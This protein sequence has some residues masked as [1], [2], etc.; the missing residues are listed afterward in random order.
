MIATGRGAVGER[1]PDP[2]PGED[3]CQDFALDRLSALETMR[4]VGEWGV[5]AA[6]EDSPKPSLNPMGTEA[7]MRHAFDHS[8][9]FERSAESQS[10]QGL[11]ARGAVATGGSSGEQ[12]GSGSHFT[13]PVDGTRSLRELVPGCR[14][15]GADDVRFTSIAES[16]QS[17][18]QGQLVAYRVGET[19]PVRLVADALACGAAGIVT[20]QLLPCPLPQCVV[21][22]VDATMAMLWSEILHHPDHKVFSI[23]VIGSAGKSTTTLMISNLLRRMGVRTAYQTDLGECDG[24]V[25]STPAE[26]MPTSDALVRWFGDAA[27]CDAQATVIELSDEDVRHGRYD[28]IR[29]DML[30]V[31]GS[32]TSNGDFG[33]SSLQCAI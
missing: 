18:E 32:A 1:W 19:D 30:V 23:G 11:G 20:E 28:T 8:P 9:E 27:D 29:F 14:V 15:I 25:Q 21:G 6:A 17:I 2:E 4:A 16:P 22:D 13:P 26:S 10:S 31:T 7:V 12:A 24:V 33:P 5:L 3:H